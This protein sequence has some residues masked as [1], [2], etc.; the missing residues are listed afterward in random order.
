MDIASKAERRKVA[1]RMLWRWGNTIDHIRRLEA[2][3]REFQAWADEARETLRAHRITGM[4]GSG[5]RGD[6]SDV[7]VRTLSRAE[8]YEREAK[9]IDAQIDDAL[10]LRRAMDALLA[11]MSAEEEKI[12]AYRYIDGHRWTYISMKMNRD[13]SGC[14]RIEQQVVD[15]VAEGLEIDAF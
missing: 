12:I 6:L 3:R 2:Y 9:T 7:L 10:R 1:R 5:K 4:P 14:R 13:E 15:R 11:G 8:K